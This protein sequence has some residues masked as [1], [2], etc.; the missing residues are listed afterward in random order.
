[1]GVACT[2]PHNKVY[3]DTI[4]SNVSRHTRKSQTETKVNQVLLKKKLEIAIGDKPMSFERVLLKFDKLRA[5]LGYVRLVFEQVA[6]DG[7]LDNQGLLTAMKQ[8]NVNLSLEDLLDLFDF[9]DVQANHVISIKE[10]LVAL[11]VGMVLDIIPALTNQSL[12]VYQTQI[13]EAHADD[14]RSPSRDE[15]E[16]IPDDDASEGGKSPKTTGEGVKEHKEKS[17][18][19]RSISRFLGHTIEV[20]EMLNLIVL[21]Y[22]IFD[23]EG[24]GYIERKTIEGM[25]Q[26]YGSSGKNNVMLSKQRWNKMVSD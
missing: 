5:V 10:F 22:L 9:V 1:M 16:T 4:C 3:H 21:A 18:L 6:K 19:R 23:P 17:P 25:F 12:E 14:Q 7:K 24:K 2:K 20:K 15:K 8:F 26:E 13:A 11:T